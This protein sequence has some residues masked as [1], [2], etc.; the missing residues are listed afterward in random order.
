LVRIARHGAKLHHHK[1]LAVLADTVS[2]VKH[3]AP[4]TYAHRQ[5]RNDHH[6]AGCDHPNGGEEALPRR[7]TCIHLSAPVTPSNSFTQRAN[8]RDGANSLSY[9]LRAFSPVSVTAARSSIKVLMTSASSPLTSG[10]AF[11][12]AL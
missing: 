10:S 12:P 6:G 2:T 4:I 5:T 3:W 8:A 11:H 9:I 1:W 7:G